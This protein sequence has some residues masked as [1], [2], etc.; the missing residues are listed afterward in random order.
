MFDLFPDGIGDEM[1][2]LQ[3]AQFGRADIDVDVE[4]A[5]RYGGLCAWRP[6][7]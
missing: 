6:P 1:G 2:L 3:C 4:A 7:R 5:R